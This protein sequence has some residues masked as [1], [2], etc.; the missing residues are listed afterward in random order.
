MNVATNSLEKH[1]ELMRRALELAH[2]EVLNLAVPLTYEIN[3]ED[4][5]VLGEKFKKSATKLNA[6]LEE[7]FAENRT[8]LISLS[9]KKIW[10]AA[11]TGA[12]FF[13]LSID[14]KTMLDSDY[15]RRFTSAEGYGKLEGWAYSLY[16]EESG[17]SRRVETLPLRENMPDIE[18]SLVD[19]LGSAALYFYSLSAKSI[20]DGD[21]LTGL[22]WL[23]EATDAEALIDGEHMWQGGFEMGE[24]KAVLTA[25]SDLARHAAASTHRENRAMKATAMTWCAEKRRGFKSKDAAAAELIK[26][27]PVKFRTAYSWIVQWEKLQSAS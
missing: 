20:R 11:W 18:E 2:G 15:T 1:Y 27:V 9:V 6:S 8:S 12:Y 14:N 24:E 19:T 16:D 23:Y 7:K 10:L 5:S 26:V 4:F 21:F 25:R 22:D 17:N 3:I 13:K